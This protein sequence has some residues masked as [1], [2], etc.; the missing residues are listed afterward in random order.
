MQFA[1]LLDIEIKRKA[2]NSMSQSKAAS[3]VPLALF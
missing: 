2:R 3:E 1:G